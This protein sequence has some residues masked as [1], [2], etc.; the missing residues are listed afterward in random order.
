MIRTGERSAA[1]YA[2]VDT[3]KVGVYDRIQ[4][5]L[6][7]E[8]GILAID[9]ISKTQFDFLLEDLSYPPDSRLQLIHKINEFTVDET[10]DRSEIIEPI[11]PDEH[12]EFV[13]PNHTDESGGNGEPNEPTKRGYAGVNKESYVGKLHGEPDRSG[14]SAQNDEP[15]GT[16]CA[17]TDELDSANIPTN[18]PKTTSSERTTESSVPTPDDILE[19]NGETYRQK[20]A[21][22]GDA[23]R[24]A[25]S[26]ISMW[27]DELG[28]DTVEI[29]DERKMASL[30]L[31]I[32]R[33][34]KL[35][36]AFNLEFSE[37]SPNNERPSESHRDGSTYAG[38]HTSFAM[39]DE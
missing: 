1:E 26:T 24:L 23:W 14:G 39:E 29:T 7:S 12:S 30:N 13:E 19:Q 3:D 27:G 21:D 33:L 38:I 37:Q 4:T 31:Y 25:G 32:Q 36:R 35:L 18:K 9:E 6:K 8:W 5:M 17:D 15:A 28:I 22:Y 2:L 11:E 34:H 10:I 16:V 20:T